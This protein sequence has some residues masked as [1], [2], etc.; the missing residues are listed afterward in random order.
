[1]LHGWP[2]LHADD[3]VRLAVLAARHGRCDSGGW[4]SA[5][6]VA[7]SS[8]RDLML[9]HPHDPSVFIGSIAALDRLLDEV[10]AVV[11]LCRVGTTQVPARCESVQV[12]LVDPPDRNVRPNIVLR[13]AVDAVAALRAESKVVFAHCFEARSRMA[14]VAALYSAR[15]RGVPL[16]Q[17]WEDVRAVLPECA[18]QRFLAETVSRIL[19]RQAALAGP[20]R[21]VTAR[22][23]HPD[24]PR[25]ERTV[26]EPPHRQEIG[27]PL[28]Q[29]LRDQGHIG[30]GEP[31]LHIGPEIPR[32]DVTLPFARNR[33]SWMARSFR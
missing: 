32:N 24:I 28:P 5:E 30:I 16:A 23:R 15:H 3:L 6:R 27:S 29:V 19:S 1:M 18:P 2:G 31:F 33:S 26:E 17:A 7:V 22:V 21:D 14:A 13:E 20:E 11:S 9:R 4:P 25:R 8:S 12:W 10:D